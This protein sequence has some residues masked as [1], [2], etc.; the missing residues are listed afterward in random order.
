MV[1]TLVE[2]GLWRMVKMMNSRFE[3]EKFNG[4][5]NFEL[6]KLKVWDL[7]VQQGLHKA[8]DG[9]TPM[10]MTYDHWEDIDA[11]ALNTIQLCLPDNVLF[12]IVGEETI[13]DLW[14]RMESLYM[15]KSLTNQIYLKRKLYSLWLKEGTKIADHLNVFSTYA[16][17]LVWM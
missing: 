15:T 3:V 1:E 8:L 2:V 12:N 14:S 7:L 17:E 16:S 6:W 11:R 5:N 4:K 10:S 13:T 9:N